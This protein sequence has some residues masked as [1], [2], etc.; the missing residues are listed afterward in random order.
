MLQPL[1]YS[2]LKQIARSPLHYQHALSS[3]FAETK[4]MRMGSAVDAIIFGTCGVVDYAGQRRGKEWQ[5]FAAANAGSI[6]LNNTEAAQ[7]RGMAK[8]LEQHSDA[9]Y[10]LNGKRQQKF[11]WTLAGRECEG[12]PDSYYPTIL[13]DLKTCESSQPERFPY[14]ARRF[15]WSAQLAWYEAGLRAAGLAEPT[16]L[17]LVAVESR[18][19]HPVTIFELT[20]KAKD[21]ANRTWRLWFERLRVCEES[22]EW[23]GYAASRVPFDAVESVE[24]LTLT[25]DGEE[26]EVE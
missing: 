23:P 2:Q 8:A 20:E 1:H 18:A 15:G 6:C 11:R 21:E 7:V 14:K 25:I 4:E 10:L 5:A 3:P 19:P 22:D 24:P 26:T 13:S 17:C 9:M 12:T 16:V